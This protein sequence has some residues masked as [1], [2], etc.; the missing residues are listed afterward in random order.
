MSVSYGA[1]CCPADVAAPAPEAMS[2]SSRMAWSSYMPICFSMS[3]L[4]VQMLDVDTAIALL[5]SP[6]RKAIETRLFLDCAGS[7]P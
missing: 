1:C 3:A 4:L 5:R 6:E 2:M 7:R